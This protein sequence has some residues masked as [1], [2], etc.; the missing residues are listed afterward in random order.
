MAA[1]G[2]EAASMPVLG[3]MRELE[4]EYHY[5]SL[6]KEYREFRLLELLPLPKSPD[7]PLQCR[8]KHVSMNDHAGLEYEAISYYWGDP[9]PCRA[10]KMDGLPLLLPINSEKALRRMALPDRIRLVFLDAACV[11]QQDLVE[12]ATQVVLMGDIYRHAQAT[13]VHLGDAV[14]TTAQAFAN[15]RNLHLELQERA[16]SKGRLQNFC[17]I[18]E[19]ARHPLKTPLNQPALVE[20]FQRPWFR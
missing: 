4:T 3:L 13:L 17:D 8:I 20:L 11:N 19:V 1:W 9:A 2:E 18:R 7:L 16:K 15:I 14:E 10:I 5:H 6:S 12:R